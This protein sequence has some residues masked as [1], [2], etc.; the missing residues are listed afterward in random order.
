MI[1]TRLGFPDQIEASLWPFFVKCTHHLAN[2]CALA[3]DEPSSYPAI[4]W[5]PGRG[6]FQS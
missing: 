2:T 5:H 6:E 4:F 1:L 3:L